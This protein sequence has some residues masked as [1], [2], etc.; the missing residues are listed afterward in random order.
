VTHRNPDIRKETMRSLV[1]RACGRR[2][3]KLARISVGAA[4]LI[5]AL[6][7]SARADDAQ[8]CHAAGGSLL[9]GR[10][11]SPPT[12]KDGMFR[13]GVELSHTHL[14]IKGDA[15]GKTYDIAIDNVFASGY[16]KN[17]KGVPAPLNTVE[18]GDKLELCGIPFSGGIHWVHNNCGDTPTKSDPN[19]WIKKVSADGSVEQN[20]EASQKYCYLWPHH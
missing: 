3:K 18:V 19:G 12:F 16:Q 7:T 5:A 4:L 1:H 2:D 20:L 17:K 14:R 11:V 13:H 9:T 10:A 15:D 6:S 8:N